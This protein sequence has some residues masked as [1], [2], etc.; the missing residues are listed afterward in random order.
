M[1]RC[2]MQVR[3]WQQRQTVPPVAARWVLPPRRCRLPAA[4]AQAVLARRTA[5][6]A[7]RGPRRRRTGRTASTLN[8][9]ATRRI[10]IRRAPRGTRG[11]CRCSARPHPRCP[12]LVGR[13]KRH[14]LLRM[15][16]SSSS[17]SSSSSLHP[18]GGVSCRR[19]LLLRAALRHRVCCPSCRHRLLLRQRPRS[20]ASNS[21]LKSE[22]SW[23]HVYK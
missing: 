14:Q 16:C 22:A 4:P 21:L 20:Q 6:A 17:S 10:S 9:G 13:S 19:C 5:R 8:Q 11:R 18:S 12:L 2:R 3:V 23:L 15:H 1:C 7:R